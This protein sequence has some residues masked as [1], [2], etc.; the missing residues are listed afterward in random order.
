MCHNQVIQ[1]TLKSQA[2][3]TATPL[4]HQ[5]LDPKTGKK[6]FQNHDL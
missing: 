3:V 6:S 4:L 2:T 1:V 5:A